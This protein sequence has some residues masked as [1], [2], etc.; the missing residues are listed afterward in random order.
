MA[1]AY[2]MLNGRTI[3]LL[4]CAACSG[5]CRLDSWLLCCGDGGGALGARLCCVCL[6]SQH[7]VVRNGLVSCARQR[8]AIVSHA[9]ESPDSLK[10][11]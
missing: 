11:A 6:V 3:G 8:R 9:M 10:A 4:S 7:E 2:C 5:F 1:T